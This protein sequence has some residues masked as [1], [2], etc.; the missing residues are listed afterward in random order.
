MTFTDKIIDSEEASYTI[1]GFADEQ[2]SEILMYKHSSDQLVPNASVHVKQLSIDRGVFDYSHPNLHTAQIRVWTDRIEKR[3]H[4]HCTCLETPLRMCQHSNRVLYEIIKNTDI[5]FFFDG[6]SRHVRVRQVARDYGLEDEADITSHFH[7]HYVENKLILTPKIQ[8]L[9]KITDENVRYLKGKLLPDV[10]PAF[11]EQNLEGKVILIYPHRHYGHL[12]IQLGELAFAVNGKV[13][14]LVNTIDATT[15]LWHEKRPEYIRF[16]AALS[17]FP[18]PTKEPYNE[19]DIR[20]LHE[21]VKN[22]FDMPVYYQGN[23]KQF[24]A[25]NFSRVNLQVIGA[26]Q[27]TLGIRK[28][29]S[30]YQISPLLQI[31][32][33]WYSMQELVFAFDCFLHI[34]KTFYAFKNHNVWRVCR[35]FKNLGTD[36][37][38]HASKYHLLQ[39][40]LLDKVSD[41]L[42]VNYAFLTEGYDQSSMETPV[43]ATERIIYLSESENYIVI[44][45]VMRYGTVEIPI[46]S[47][48][49]VYGK[50]DYGNS[51]LIRRNDEQELQFLSFILKQHPYFPE[52]LD[53]DLLYFYLHQDRFF[54]GNW[55]LEAFEQ[56][57]IEKIAV[58]G[59]DK[60]S[61][62]KRSPYKAAINIEVTSG[63]NWFNTRVKISYGSKVARLRD[64]EKAV[65]NKSNYVL[66]DDGT[67]GILPAEWLHKFE[68]FFSLGRREGDLLKT[69]KINFQALQSAYETDM[70]DSGV[71]QEL[72]LFKQWSNQEEDP[73]LKIPEGFIGKLRPYQL[74]GVK[75][76]HSLSRLGFGGCL[77]DDMG[78]GKSIQIIA[79]L[80]LKKEEGKSGTNL[81]VVPATLLTNWLQEF[82]KFAPSLRIF[83]WHG[84][85]RDQN[86]TIDSW[87]VV[88]T[89]YG[90]MVSD[91]DRFQEI[92]FDHLFLDESQHIKN[93]LS[94]RYRAA[95]R[96]KAKIKIAV[97]GTPLENNTFDLFGQLSF[98]CPGL[99]GNKRYF[100]DVYSTPIDK[101][102]ENRRLEELLHKIKPFV[103]R[104]TKAEVM[105][106]LPEKTEMVMYCE[107]GE[108]QRRIYDVY[109]KEFRSYISAQTEEELS[110]K[111]AVVLKGL[112]RLRQICNSP[113]LLKDKYSNVPNAAK[114]EWL[115]E[116][117]GQRSVQHKILLF[118][119]YVHM[120]DL[121]EDQLHKQGLQ[122]LKMTGSTKVKDRE[123]LIE[124]FKL[125]GRVKVFLM[126]LKVGGV[127]LNLTEADYVYLIDPWWNPAVEDQAI[128]RIYRMGQ[129]KNVIA[130]R[131]ICKETIE[132]KVL[133]LQQSKSELFTKLVDSI[134]LTKTSFSK[135][136][137]LQ[138]LSR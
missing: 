36:L 26:D 103:L 60:L 19:D 82:E 8:G 107:M 70:F 79:F 45:P 122:T 27:F 102:G 56:W 44:E 110:N 126:S 83:L 61:I 76:L 71:K 75:W 20:A 135:E 133:Q 78:L 88:L 112:M 74:D 86:H 18:Q 62:S 73:S 63:I 92:E 40:E 24:Q 42:K 33:Q 3:L 23:S 11:R 48:R 119:Q 34:G 81:I 131:L 130:V 85:Q 9:L 94:Q 22:P 93:P 77:A 50:D 80:L 128:D 66:L 67:Y 91:L 32:D 54:D 7:M 101:F 129:K 2:L 15:L 57:Q 10:K 89:T 28:K 25:K 127:G 98:A 134:T 17:R 108:E 123:G 39:S 125:D 137:L 51:F 59:Y 37:I 99:L 68:Q 117:I 95:N 96:L 65:R 120:L 1:E 58:M 12:T 14:A 69:A 13:K 124:Q 4:F 113:L 72:L 138:L 105:D 46:R 49:P 84:G 109:E 116:E 52:Q 97:T 29:D 21:I 64:L 90:T 5:R 6:I 30:L 35:F 115:I 136:A 38:V 31:A 118:S 43:Q 121:V 47:K 106:D 114:I 132:E 87:D 55:F 104:R 16:L 111:S 41:T 53:D 100:R